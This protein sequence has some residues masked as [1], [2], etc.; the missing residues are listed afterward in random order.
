MK[1]LLRS[2]FV[3]I[4]II[5]GLAAGSTAANDLARPFDPV[6]IKG[7]NFPDFLNANVSDLHVYAYRSGGWSQIPFQIDEIDSASYFTCHNGLFDARD[8]LCLIAT[9]MGDSAADNHWIGNLESMA[10]QRYQICAMDTSVAPHHKAYAYVYRSPSLGAA[11]TPYMTY[12]PPTVESADTIRAV[13]YIFAHDHNSIPSHLQLQHGSEFGPDLMDRWKIHFVGNLFGFKPFDENES[14]ALQ[15]T[16]I[17]VRSGPVRIIRKGMFNIFLEDTLSLE[18][19]ISLTFKFY[20][21]TAQ[22]N[23]AEEDLSYVLGITQM[24]QRVDYNENVLGGKFH[25]EKQY[26]IDVDGNSMADDLSDVTMSAPGTHWY[27]LAGSFGTIVTVFRCDAIPNTVQSLFFLDDTSK[28][29]GVL[30]K[31]TGDSMAIGE[32]GVLL[33]STPGDVIEVEKKNLTATF[34]YLGE[35]H[36]AAFGDTLKE[37]MDRPLLISVIPRRNDVIPVELAFFNARI[38]ENGVE[39]TWATASETNNYGFQMQRKVSAASEWQTIAFIRGHGT[40]AEN[41]QYRYVDEVEESGRYDYRLAQ[42]DTDGRI[43]YSAPVTV[44]TAMPQQLTLAQNYPNPFNPWTEILVEVPAPLKGR[45]S[46]TVHNLLGQKVRTLVD[47]ELTAGVHRI[48]WDGCDDLGRP[49]GSGVYFY[50]LEGGGTAQVRKM[51]KM[52]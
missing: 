37:Q 7:S 25:W 36:N 14:T 32:S 42:L 39:L 40:T 30:R 4:L 43:S 17:Y 52:Q 3:I 29:D 11:F 41:H 1:V 12:I 38:I 21:K 5:L 22:I 35:E 13:S 31:D 44:T 28:A 46:L 16:M 47:E 27:M 23:L 6:V 34:Y 8:E 51:I 26:D 2:W 9:D 49:Q 33:R 19:M 20:P 50:R 45:L 15:D 10:Y 48:R 24:S 18:K